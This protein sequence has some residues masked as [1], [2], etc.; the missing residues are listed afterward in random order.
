MSQE[1]KPTDSK[2]SKATEIAVGTPPAPQ[3]AIEPLASEDMPSIVKKDEPTAQQVFFAWEKLRLAY[4][5]VL[6]F[7]VLVQISFG[8]EFPFLVLN[9][10]VANVF[11]CAGPVAEG[12]LVLLG[13]PRLP[14]RW[15]ICLFGTVIAVI[16]TFAFTWKPALLR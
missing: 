7:V 16:V 14:F 6:V 3:T 10:I 11:F 8:A 4:N 12:Y 5:A 15:L 13:V 9:A 1:S 2:S